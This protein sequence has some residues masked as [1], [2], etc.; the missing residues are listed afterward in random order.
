MGVQDKW[1]WPA[2]VVVGFGLVGV[3][4]VAIPTIVITYAIDSYKP[5]TGEIMVIA[6]VCKNT[7]GVSLSEGGTHLYPSNLHNVVWYDLLYERLGG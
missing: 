1:P 4:V 6:T 2:V 7:F 5:V 3:Q